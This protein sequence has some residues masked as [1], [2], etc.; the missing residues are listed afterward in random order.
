[1][2]VFQGIFQSEGTPEGRGLQQ[3]KLA[4]PG[5]ARSQLG[6]LSTKL[7]LFE[8][9]SKFKAMVFQSMIE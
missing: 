6:L 8:T 4:P 2:T 3:N 1:M 7:V 5:S 9:A